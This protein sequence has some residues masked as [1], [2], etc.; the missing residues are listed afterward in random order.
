[1]ILAM[2]LLS[3]HNPF[4]ELSAFIETRN[5]KKVPLY[6]TNGFMEYQ[7]KYESFDSDLIRSNPKVSIIIPT[8]NRYEY[9]K[10]VIIDLENQW[11][12]I[13]GKNAGKHGYADRG[14]F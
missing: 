4:T 5:V 11:G 13:S 7:K 10:D 3:L 14:K 1:M 8:L 2:R 6:M 12:K 9:L